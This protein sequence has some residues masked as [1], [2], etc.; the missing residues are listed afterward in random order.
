MPVHVVFL[1]LI[2]DPACSI[3][4]DAEPEEAGIMARPPRKHDELLFGKRTVLVGLLQ[5]F[6]VLVTTLAVYGGFLFF[7]YE[8]NH[9][10]AAGFSALVMG[11]LALIFTNRSG[12]RTIWE[13]L[14]SRNRWLWTIVLGSTSTLLLALYL[15]VLRSVFHFSILPLRDMLLAALAGFFGVLWFEVLKLT[16][17]RF[18]RLR[19]KPQVKA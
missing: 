2:I 10:R 14:Q 12:T 19:G 9:S 15:P 18:R 3:A 8:E 13:T 17:G 1:E 16:S 5:G 7:G 6:T 11:N 4:F